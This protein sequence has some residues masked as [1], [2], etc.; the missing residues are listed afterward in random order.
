MKIVYFYQYFSTPK[1]SW[2]TRVYD[3]S[4]EWID[5]GYQVTVV[6]SIYSKSDIKATKF[7]DRQNIDGID[8]IIINISIDNKHSFL[9]RIFSFLIYSFISCWYA[10]TLNAN[11]VI[12]SSGPI[13]VGISGLMAKW[14]RGRKFIFETR[15]LWPD[16]AIELGVVKNRLLIKLS[17]L[18]ESI[19]YKNADLI[20]CLSPGMVSNIK[21]RFGIN[22][23]ISVTNGVDLE[24]FNKKHLNSNLPNFF[25]TQKVAIYAGNIGDVNNTSLLLR[26]AK[27]LKEKER[28]DIIVYII[29]DGQLKNKLIDLKNELCLENLIFENL[30]PKKKL[31]NY[32]QNSMVSLIPLNSMPILDTSSPNKLF[33]SLAAGVPII[34][35][36]KG[37]IKDLIAE[38]KCGFTVDAHDESDMAQV[39]IE[40]ADNYDLAIEMGNNARVLAEKE[41]NKKIL[42]KRMLDAIIQ[43]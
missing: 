26:V 40:L 43:L 20:V 16:G 3:F 25:I 15:D 24:L 29:G 30:I 2:G 32:F 21:K 33:E 37:W 27:L 5:S 42:A 7:I 11:L 17:H 23:M 35:T 8:V 28:T 18:F 14:V 34:Q 41:F 9:K 36:T 4:K 38:N 31:V 39:L 1:G 10:I 12:T 13:S 19:C 22:K 6:T